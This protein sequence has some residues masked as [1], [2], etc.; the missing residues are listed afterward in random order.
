MG[1]LLL[2]SAL[3]IFLYMNVLYLVALLSK[4]VGLVD[5]GWGMGF[6]IVAWTCAIVA[7]AVPTSVQSIVLAAVTVWGARLSW[8]IGR[9]NIGS[10][11]D[12]RYANWRREWG[13][14]YIWRSYLQ[15]FMLQGFMMWLISTSIVVAFV[16]NSVSPHYGIFS[17]GVFIWLLGFYFELVGDWQ[18]AR[19][20]K[21]R[22][23]GKTTQK[24]MTEGL[25]RFSRHPNYFG[26]V[27]QWWG[28]WLMIV[29]LPWGW[30]AIISPVVI[31]W[32]IIFVS[33]VPMLEK[34]Y[35]KNETYQAYACRTSKFIPLPP[36]R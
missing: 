10:P 24:I 34:K 13:S 36:K 17:L 3:T 14:S 4:N 1:E 7:A 23:S 2:V 25:W 35:A 9:R 22:A 26:E 21:R 15:I 32:L 5:V 33:G 18:L 11:E 29:S 12:W 27:A 16:N 30:A 28:I 19:F 31:S 6:I 8:H 20:V